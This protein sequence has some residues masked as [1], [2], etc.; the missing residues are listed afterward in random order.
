MRVM[1]VERNMCELC[2]KREATLFMVVHDG[3]TAMADACLECFEEVQ[4]VP[5]GSVEAVSR[6]DCRETTEG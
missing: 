3:K 1:K 2:G 5:S 4:E 6:Q